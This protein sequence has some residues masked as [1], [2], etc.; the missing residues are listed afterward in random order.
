MQ[1]SKRLLT[2]ILGRSL[3]RDLLVLRLTHLPPNNAWPPRDNREAGV[4]ENEIVVATKHD[5]HGSVGVLL[6]QYSA[7]ISAWSRLNMQECQIGVVQVT[8][9]T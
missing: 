8:R 4:V 5:H 9:N 6:L 1:A 7:V 2:G 3:G